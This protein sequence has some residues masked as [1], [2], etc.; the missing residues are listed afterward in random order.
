MGR[1]GWWAGGGGVDWRRGKVRTGNAHGLLVRYA[2]QPKTLVSDRPS[3]PYR[4]WEC[5]GYIGD[6][7][8]CC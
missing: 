4:D 2:A 3:Q 7:C 5:M 6:C 1:G 8:C